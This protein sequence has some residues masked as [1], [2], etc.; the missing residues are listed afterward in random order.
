MKYT[1]TLFFIL[2]YLFS[3]SQAATLNSQPGKTP[4]C[5]TFITKVDIAN[6]TKEGIYLNGY[7]VNID[8]GQLKNLN[9]K[10]NKVTG[11]VTIVKGL[12]SE[13][14][15]YEKNGQEIIKQGRSEDSKH[16]LSPKIK[17]IK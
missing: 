7:V 3:F 10:T 4:K 8:Y 1:L 5:V 6:A 16:I 9:G 12:N 13:P 15:E 17:I 11:K 2:F 14:K